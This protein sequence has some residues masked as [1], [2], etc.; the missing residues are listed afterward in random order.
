M[1][2]DSNFDGWMTINDVN[3]ASW[4]QLWWSYIVV[5]NEVFW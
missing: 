4:V 2:E 3:M 5:E 1:C